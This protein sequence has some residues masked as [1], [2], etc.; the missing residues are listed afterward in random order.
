VSTRLEL[1]IFGRIAL[2]TLCGY[3]IGLEREYR[4]KVAGERTFALLALGA[5]GLVALAM[6]R[7]PISADRVIQ[8]VA[9]GIGFLGA[10]LIFRAG[11]HPRGLTTA[12]AAWAATAIGV[13][14]GAA[15]YLAAILSTLLTIV[16]LESQQL[17]II[18]GLHEHTEDGSSDDGGSHG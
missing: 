17:S 6:V 9:T 16:I 18:R 7:F 4:G 10:G 14:C 3:V 12:A 8:G 13:M 5:S 15:I 2:A 1:A 11:G